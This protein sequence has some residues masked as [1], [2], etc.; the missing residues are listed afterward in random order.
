MRAFQIEIKRHSFGG[1]FRKRNPA[2]PEPSLYRTSGRLYPLLHAGFQAALVSP[3][4]ATLKT[5]YLVRSNPA[6][7]PMFRPKA[8]VRNKFRRA[9]GLYPV[10]SVSG[11]R[12]V[13][14]RYETHT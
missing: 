4:N 2:R 11:A 8:Y 7:D 12:Q 1:S 9:N 3:E 14:G 6:R 5:S 10:L 13:L